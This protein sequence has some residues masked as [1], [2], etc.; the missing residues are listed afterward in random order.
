MSTISAPNV[1]QQGID[2]AKA[3]N[4]PLARQYLLQALEKYAGTEACWLWLA[5]VAETLEERSGYLQQALVINPQNQRAIQMLQQTERQLEQSQPAAPAWHCPLCETAAPQ[6]VERCPACGAL[7]TAVDLQLFLSNQGVKQE[8]VYEAIH[9]LKN[10]PAHNGD[11]ATQFYHLGLAYLNL[12]QVEQALP[13]VQGAARLRPTDS[14]LARLLL[15]IPQ[16]G[17][18]AVAAPKPRQ[19]T[20]LIVDDSSTIC[21]LV[22]MTLA[23]QDYEVIVAVDGID[24]LAKLNEELPDLILLDITMPRMDGYQ[25]C[26]VVKGNSETADIPVVMLSG[27]DG[28]FD[29]VR[30]RMVG[31][32]D[33]ITKPFEPQELV[34]VVRRHLAVKQTS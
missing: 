4:K 22:S 28:F 24:A 21:K 15:Q 18:T 6:S 33:Y 10:G 3:G 2:A 17:E 13:F 9:R 20:I 30:G 25:V 1:L 16:H 32:T 8:M 27:K 11:R 31:A 5:V 19:G 7:L 29:K 12:G 26:K 14:Q 34:K 23:R